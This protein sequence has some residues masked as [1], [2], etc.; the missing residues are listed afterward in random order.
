MLL[1]VEKGIRS[2]ICHA[3]NKYVKDFDQNKEQYLMYYDVNNLHGWALSHKLP[4]DDVKWVR[5]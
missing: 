1:V 5:K 2:G 4:V 3:N